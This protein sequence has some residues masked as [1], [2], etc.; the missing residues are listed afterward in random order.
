MFTSF[1]V[2]IRKF[3]IVK[4]WEMYAEHPL[5]EL[6]HSSNAN[7]PSC[8][9][10][11]YHAHE[12]MAFS[13][14]IYQISNQVSIFFRLTQIPIMLLKLTHAVYMLSFLLFIINDDYGDNSIEILKRSV[15]C[16]GYIP[17]EFKFCRL[18]IWK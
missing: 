18:N 13:T 3:K 16:L 14:H 12:N 9:P 5:S 2:L 15:K 8:I 10:L 4:S 17:S 1:S 7:N 11:L 6:R